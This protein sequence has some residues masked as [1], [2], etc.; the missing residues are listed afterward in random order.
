MCRYIQN[1]HYV[2]W[3]GFEN[4]QSQDRFD[5]ATAEPI[6]TTVDFH[7]EEK[8]NMWDFFVLFVIFLQLLLIFQIIIH[9]ASEARVFINRITCRE[10]RM[11]PHN[12][13]RSV[14]YSTVCR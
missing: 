12:D 5:G 14:I 10:Q 7:S 6:Y 13:D 2:N 8:S 4:N 1:T 3:P 11:D 9:V